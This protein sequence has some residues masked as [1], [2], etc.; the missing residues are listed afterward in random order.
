MVNRHILLHHTVPITGLVLCSYKKLPACQT[1]KIPCI[2]L[3]HWL[4]TKKVYK[5]QHYYYYYYY[6]YY[7]RTPLIWIKWDKPFGNAENPDNWIFL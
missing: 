3:K 1:T 7:S 6:Y 5:I 2:Q 4:L